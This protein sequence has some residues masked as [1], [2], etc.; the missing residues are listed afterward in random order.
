M[1]GGREPAPELP[2]SDRAVHAQLVGGSAGELRARPVAGGVLAQVP[3]GRGQA[4][5]QGEL[6][7]CD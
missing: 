5:A 3:H 2:A 7:V 1:C 6:G 4:V